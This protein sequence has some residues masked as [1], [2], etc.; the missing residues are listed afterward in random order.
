MLNLTDVTHV[1]PNNTRALDGVTLE[2]PRGM[3]GLGPNG[4]GKSTLMRSI[5]TLQTPSSGAIT[6]DGVD[7]VL[8]PRRLGLDWAIYHRILV[9]IP[10]DCL[11]HAR[12]HGGAQGYC[13]QCRAQRNGRD[14][15]ESGQSLEGA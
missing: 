13:W 1:Y 2:I 15:L 7:V 14:A 4:A 10:G 6:F 11:R 8:S 12:A 3:Y 9:F 5:A